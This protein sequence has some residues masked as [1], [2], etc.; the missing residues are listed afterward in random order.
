MKVCLD[1]R[2]SPEYLKQAD[3]IKVQSRDAGIIM[4]LIEKYPKAT[5]VL[6]IPSHEN[7][8]NWK[9]IC[10]YYILSRHQFIL[11]LGNIEDIKRAVE[12][13]IPCFY[14]YAIETY[15]SLRSF[16]RLGVSYVRLGVPLFFEL[17]KVMNVLGENGPKIRGIA[18]ITYMDRLP[19]GDG[20]SGM[21]IRPE[22][23]DKYDKY[24]YSI[25]FDGVPVNKEEALFRIYIKQKSWAGPFNLLIEGLQT[26]AANRMISSD[27]TD[28]RLNC[29]QRCES[30]GHCHNCY[31]E[32]HM[33]NPSIYSPESLD[34][35]MKLLGVTK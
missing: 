32:L 5:I 17:D 16:M 29:G 19:H 13:G 24:F 18:N 33:S 4:D 8:L 27:I 11:C 35:L 28:K 26:S 10:D 9:E 6:Q 14:G 25:E 1:A 34:S 3:E 23:L 12:E 21:W 30:G 7:E 31:T 20:I 15:A 22:D 2:V